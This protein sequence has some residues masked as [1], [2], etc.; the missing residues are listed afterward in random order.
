M[1]GDFYN[2]VLTENKDWKDKMLKKER[3]LKHMSILVD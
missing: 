1:K 3:N 2:M